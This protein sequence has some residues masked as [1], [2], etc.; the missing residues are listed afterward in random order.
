MNLSL[1]QI[2]QLIYSR[3]NPTQNL[4]LRCLVTPY[5]VFGVYLNNLNKCRLKRRRQVI[6]YGVASSRYYYWLSR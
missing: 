5:V 2:H 4:W 3:H 1:F 6:V